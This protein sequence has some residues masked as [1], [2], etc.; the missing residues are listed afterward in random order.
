MC[1]TQNTSNIIEFNEVFYIS[2]KFVKPP[3]LP[4]KSSYCEFLR[5]QN[6]PA[7]GKA[8]VFISHA[9]RYQFLDVMD[10]VRDHFKNKP[11]IIIWFDMFSNNQHKAVDLTF[12]WW[13]NTF[14]SAIKEFGH[15]VMVIAPW[16]DPITLT[17]AWCLFEIYCTVSTNSKFEV[18]LSDEQR[19]IFIRDMGLHGSEAID[20]MLATIDAER[21]D[22]WRAEDKARIFEAVRLTVGFNHI[23]A[24]VFGEM[25]KFVIRTSER[26]FDNEK[27]VLLKIQYAVILASLYTSQG[28]L[29][30]AE[31]ILYASVIA[32]KALKGEYDPLTLDAETNLAILYE[33]EDN[34]SAAEPLYLTCLEK[35]E[36]IYGRTHKSTLAAM[37]NLANVFS[38]RQKYDAAEQLY[39]ECFKRRS[40]EFGPMDIDTISALSNL[41]ALY[42][43]MGKL[44]KAAEL[45]ADCVERSKKNL[46]GDHPYTLIAMNN[47]ASIQDL[48]FLHD[49]AEKLLV[50]VLQTRLMSMGEQDPEYL[51]S[52]FNLGVH[53]RNRGLYAKALPLLDDCANK[54]L[55]VLGPNHPTTLKTIEYVEN[56]NNKLYSMISDAEN[57]MEEV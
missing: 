5:A 23:N 47:L 20:K 8:Q 41:A 9:W 48:M 15:T 35:H 22:A 55:M 50:Y 32:S 26:S 11:E 19:R 31:P 36:K 43:T 27:S 56:V 24:L 54:R 17:R 37:N 2:E 44:E 18:A 16:N 7:V 3:T 28:R 45:A 42:L 21:S 40:E 51:N 13:C 52:L 6:H 29:L 10:A 30:S 25:R 1:G 12:D 33:N 46:D 53:Y 14:K 57:I 38:N 49:D 4:Y 39:S 34:F